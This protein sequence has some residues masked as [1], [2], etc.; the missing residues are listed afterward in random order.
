MKKIFLIFTLG[1]VSI[2]MY[3]QEEDIP[4]GDGKAREKIQAARIAYITEKL[5]LTPAEA[6]KFWPVYREFAI[7]RH[8][9][10]QQLKDTREKPGVTEKE[11]VD[12]GLQFKQRDLDLEKEYSGK[13]LNV[14]S[15][16][17]LLSLRNAEDEFRVMILKQLQQRQMQQERKQQFRDRNQQRLQQRNN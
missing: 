3:A 10:K 7:K 4:K 16:Q 15:A 13:L 14:I 11:L 17:K 9:L 5:G 8:E 1:L 6:E 12:A 2:S